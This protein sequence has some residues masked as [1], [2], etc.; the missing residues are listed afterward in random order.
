MSVSDKVVRRYLVAIEFP[1]PKALKDYLAKHPK[2]DRSKHT[3]VKGKP[4]APKEKTVYRDPTPQEIA[5]AKKAGKSTKW[6]KPNLEEESGEINR[7][8]KSLKIEPKKLM[9][10]CKTAELE[11]LSDKDWSR[12]ENSDSYDTDTIEKAAGKAKEYNRDIARTLNG[13]GKEMPASIV[14]FR[15][16]QPPYLIGGNTRLMSARAV[17]AKP[18]V[19]A[20]R[21]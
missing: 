6:H 14:L 3:V 1:T 16:G 10:A 18:K 2:A 11:S 12:L 5:K 7:T 4:K 13:M 19:L 20:V 15:K 9:Q 8:A 17:G 21:L